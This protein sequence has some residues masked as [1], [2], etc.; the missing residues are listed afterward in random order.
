MR[1]DV[2]A[3]KD[4]V[5]DICD[6]N[7]GNNRLTVISYSKLDGQPA[8][9]CTFKKNPY[10]PINIASLPGQSI[11]R[12]V[13]HTTRKSLWELQYIVRRS[14][15]RSQCLGD[16]VLSCGL[17]S[18]GQLVISNFP[19]TTNVWLTVSNSFLNSHALRLYLAYQF[20]ITGMYQ[21]GLMMVAVDLD[22]SKIDRAGSY[23]KRQVESTFLLPD[24]KKNLVHSQS[25]HGRPSNETMQTASHEQLE[26]T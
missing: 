19:V 20:Q 24:L 4:C 25:V 2:R 9:L 1:L 12:N 10:L 8:A 18:L 21:S 5:R 11:S 16:I 15:L 3:Y 7:D 26:V 6:N 22:G 17:Q 23:M 13:L 14:N